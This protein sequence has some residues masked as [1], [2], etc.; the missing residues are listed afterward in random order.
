MATQ[1]QN[2]LVGTLVLVCLGV[3]FL[4]DLFDGKKEHN[5]ENFQSIPLQEEF[6]ERVLAS[7]L[8]VPLELPEGHLEQVKEN[9]ALPLEITKNSEI[10]KDHEIRKEPEIQHPLNSAHQDSGWIIRL[11]TFRNIENAQSLVSKLRKKGYPAQLMPRNIKEGQL[12]R[13]EV[14]PELSKNK[15][16]A[17]TPDIEVLTGLKGQ[18]IRF[19][20]LA[21]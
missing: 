10:T 20:P 8:K 1:F 19:N 12:A 5:K 6:K 11:G 13:V 9:A 4:P 17:M 18:L 16:E 2:R 14:G 15:L 21:P 7:S 3:I